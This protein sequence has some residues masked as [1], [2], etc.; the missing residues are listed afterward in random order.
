MIRTL[1]AFLNDVEQ[2]PPAEA[3]ILVGTCLLPKVY[4][5]IAYDLSV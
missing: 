4:R 2:T 5:H 1:N 3:A